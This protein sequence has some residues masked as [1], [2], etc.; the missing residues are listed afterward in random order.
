MLI[1]PFLLF[2]LKAH[3]HGSS[4]GDKSEN[5]AL[6]ENKIG[7]NSDDVVISHTEEATEEVPV[8][9]QSSSQLNMRGVFLHVLGDALGSVIVIISALIIWFAEG[10]WRFYVDPAMSIAMVLLILSTTI[11]L[12]R[13][14]GLILLQTVP[15][16]IQVKDIKEKLERVSFFFSSS[17]FPF[18]DL[19][20]D[21]Y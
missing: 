6:V 3:S 17:S 1:I 7:G 15:T 20:P 12:L 14:S 21:S 8:K 10:D 18:I 5:V 4:H 19:Q 13:E 9:I 2:L 16:H 11:P